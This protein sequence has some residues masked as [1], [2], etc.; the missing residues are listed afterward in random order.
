[1][2]TEKSIKQKNKDDTNMQDKGTLT[3]DKLVRQVRSLKDRNF[4]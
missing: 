4:L 1:M 3:V 2:E